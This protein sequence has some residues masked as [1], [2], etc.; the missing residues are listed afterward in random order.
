M[1]QPICV[2]LRKPLRK[3]YQKPLHRFT[4]QTRM[5]TGIREHCASR[6]FGLSA[7]CYSYIPSLHRIPIVAPDSIKYLAQSSYEFVLSSLFIFHPA[8][9]SLRSLRL[10]NPILKLIF[11][12]VTSPAPLPHAHT[13]RITMDGAQGFMSAPDL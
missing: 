12:D 9:R 8:L 3:V 7:V 11:S 2:H 10:M 13:R 1:K 4:S 6:S 5:P